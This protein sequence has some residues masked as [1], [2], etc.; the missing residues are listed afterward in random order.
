MVL[1]VLVLRCLNARCNSE[2][3]VQRCRTEAGRGPKKRS[4]MPLQGYQPFPN[5]DTN[6]TTLKRNSL[7]RRCSFEN[8]TTTAADIE[9]FLQDQ[10]DQPCPMEGTKQG[11]VKQ[12]TIP[13]SADRCCDWKKTASDSLQLGHCLFDLGSCCK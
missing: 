1:G 5:L 13:V 9:Q 8:G 12:H 3:Y 2:R 6:R 10:L 11:N 7:L 4:I